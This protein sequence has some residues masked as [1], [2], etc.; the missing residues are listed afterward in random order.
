MK[1]LF[2]DFFEISEDII[3]DYGAF[4]VSLVSDLP[5]FIDP[6]RI[7]NSAK[8]EYQKLH[9][10]IIKYLIYLRDKSLA[11]NLETAFLADLFTFPEVKQNWL[12][13]SKTSNKGSGLGME[14]AL[15]LDKNFKILKGFGKEKISG[16]HLEKLTLIN[17]G[18][19]RDNISDFT[20]NLI[21]EFLLEYTQNFARKHLPAKFRQVHGMNKV[22]FNYKTQVWEDGIFELPNYDNSIKDNYVILTPSDLL[23]KDETWINRDELL[24]KFQKIANSVD[25]DILKRRV[26]DYFHERLSKI[27]PKEKKKDGTPKEPAAKYKRQA[28]SETIEQYPE[29]LDHFLKYKEQNGEEGDAA[30]SLKVIQSKLLYLKQFSKLAKDLLETTTFYKINTSTYDGCLKKLKVLKKFVENENGYEI[31]HFNKKPVTDEDNLSILFRM[32]WKAHLPQKDT[33]SDS[34]EIITVWKKSKT[35]LKIV[36]KLSTNHRL[37]QTL[38]KLRDA[39]QDQKTEQEYI[40]VIVHYSKEELDSVKS[41][42]KTLGMSNHKNVVFINAEMI[43]NNKNDEEVIKNDLDD[44]SKTKSKSIK[45]NGYGLLV[46]VGYDLPE[47]VDD[48]TAI[49]NVLVNPKRAAYPKQNVQLL[50]EDDST[51]KDIL[52]AF[53]K[54]I[55]ESQK[56]SIDTAI[57]YYSG[58][59]W[60]NGKEYYLAPFGYDISRPKETLIS[61]KEFTGKI[62]EINAKKLLVILDCCYAGGI[63]KTKTVKGLIKS[64][65]PKDFLD[66]LNKGS[67]KVVIASSSEN[68]KS[69]ILDGEPNSVFTQCFLEALEGKGT[70]HKDGYAKIF[71]ILSYVFKEVKI[72]TNYKQHPFLNNATNL[73]DDFAV[74]YYAGGVKDIPNAGVSSDSTST[75]ITSSKLFRLRDKLTGLEATRKLLVT[76]ANRYRNEIIIE[77]DLAAKMKLEHKYIETEADLKNVEAEIDELE[78]QIGE[79]S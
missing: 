58:H 20:T 61:G 76:K 1:Q 56:I 23:T 15:A 65:P 8:P 43:E 48:A 53:D 3:E 63:P 55:E 27:A 45:F 12:G 62:N 59:G 18:V 57:I 50:T 64:N 32:T 74:C 51:R 2:S 5:L 4:N 26:N 38:E 52:D 41:L 34:A 78:N 75:T 7:F 69:L 21:K 33:F 24:S 37:K 22:K 17:D 60:T 11:G 49:Y 47:T 29:I 19:G 70:R 44:S 73:S 67:G 40:L 6:F 42:L 71:D 9:D 68:E 36:L 10:E 30:S 25:S 16:S 46:G 66:K 39:Y 77:S 35:K 28:A 72:R 31:F 54:L 14:F 13:Y 79:N